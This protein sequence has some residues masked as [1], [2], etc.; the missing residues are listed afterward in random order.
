[1]INLTHVLYIFTILFD[2]NLS[3]DHWF[4]ILN[5]KTDF[6]TGMSG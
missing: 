2:E 6:K 1:M 4:Y 5:F 3:E